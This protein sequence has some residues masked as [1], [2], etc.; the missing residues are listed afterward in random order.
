MVTIVI[1]AIYHAVYS[2]GR[3]VESMFVRASDTGIYW[4][5]SMA[6]A[7]VPA[8]HAGSEGNPGVDVAPFR[9]NP[10]AR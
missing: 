5:L 6:R 10:F 7:L 2:L 8:G 9:F 3:G 1:W 4:F